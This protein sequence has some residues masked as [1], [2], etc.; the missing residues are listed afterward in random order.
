MVE[1]VLQKVILGKIREI[2]L[3]DMWYVTCPENTNI[4]DN[5]FSVAASIKLRS[6]GFGNTAEKVAE[7][8]SGEMGS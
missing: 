7:Q 4:H 8:S 2:C 6:T 3:L 1:I 5:S